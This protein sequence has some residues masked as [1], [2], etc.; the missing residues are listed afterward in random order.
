MKLMQVG[1]VISCKYAIQGVGKRH[2]SHN[3]L[4][5]QGDGGFLGQMDEAE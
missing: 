1:G 5:L 3:C 2:E 4:G